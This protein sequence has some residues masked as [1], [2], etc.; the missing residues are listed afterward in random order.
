[1][2]AESIA[3]DSTNLML[4]RRSGIKRYLSG[5]IPALAR[6]APDLRFTAW[7]GFLCPA[8]RD[9]F[10]DFGEPNVRT[11]PLRLPRRLFENAWRRGL[12][13]AEWIAPGARVFH[14]FWYHLPPARRT[15]RILTVFDFREVALADL[16][17][18]E[19][20][21][22]RGLFRRSL[23]EADVIVASTRATAR[24]LRA[25]FPLEGREIE[26]VH[27]AVDDSFRPQGEEAVASTRRRLGVTGPYAAAIG[28]GDPRKNI[29]WAIRAFVR[30]IERS[31]DDLR[32]VIAGARHTSDAAALAEADG[33][34][35]AGRIIHVGETSDEDW[36]NLL[37]GAEALIYP[38]L[39]EGLGLPPLEGMACGAPVLASDLPAVKE[40]AG[41]AARY[42]DPREEEGLVEALSELRG[43]SG[44][45]ARLRSAGGLR[46]KEFTWDR[47]AR[48]Y[49]RIY[50]K[51]LEG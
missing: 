3:I 5:L 16:Y 48:D 35:H 20:E 32:L 45:A 8:H 25:H 42:F 27:G 17:P 51:V 12:L 40:W 11:L 46:V 24:D 22:V 39:Y 31:G 38:S 44:L 23:L 33:A 7:M 21:R 43:S 14:S 18:G 37:S 49:L 19:T 2:R 41:D 36:R 9:G 50:R 30:Y 1:M 4:E 29:P 6:A 26:V 28:S 47:I 34:G 13:P 15:R 10:P